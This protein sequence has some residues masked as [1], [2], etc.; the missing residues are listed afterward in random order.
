MTTITK[1]RIYCETIGQWVETWR[2]TPP[3]TCPINDTHTVN[4]NSVQELETISPNTVKIDEESVGKTTGKNF[5]AESYTMICPTGTSVH[6]YQWVRPISVCETNFISTD[7]HIGDFVN[8]YVGG[9][10]PVGVLTTGIETGANIL[11]VSQTV[12]DNTF[13]GYKII[14]KTGATGPTS[15]EFGEL[16]IH[17]TVDNEL[18]TEL[19]ASQSH[20]AGS[21]IF[22]QSQ[23]MK[24]YKIVSSGFHG[25]GINRKSSSY[26]PEN[27]PSNI[28]Y[29]NNGTGTK[30]ITF[31]VE[32]L[33]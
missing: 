31:F 17:N 12:I 25:I 6:T 5:R 33:Y 13:I 27:T 32:Y 10:S 19:T 8:N 4:G 11:P 29:T 28:H 30:E 23:I 14:I 21:Y 18:T 24:N 26:L 16:L 7:E 9:N 1:Y 20:P 2:E 15:Y 3:T 22:F